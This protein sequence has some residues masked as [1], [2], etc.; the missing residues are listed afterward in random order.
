MPL[1]PAKLL[2][3]TAAFGTSFVY[4]GAGKS[5]TGALPEPGRPETRSVRIAQPSVRRGDLNHDGQAY[6]FP[7]P[8]DRL[9]EKFKLSTQSQPLTPRIGGALYPVSAQLDTRQTTIEVANVNFVAYG[10]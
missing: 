4:G 2:F 9:G 3:A 7:D 1:L 10:I 6:Y 8:E 5:L